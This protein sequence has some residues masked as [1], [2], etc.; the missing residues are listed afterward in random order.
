MNSL[1]EN[2]SMFQTYMNTFERSNYNSMQQAYLHPTY[3][4]GKALFNKN[5]KGAIINLNL[6]KLKETADYSTTPH[7]DPGKPISGLEAY[8]LYIKE[9]LPFLKASGGEI[10]FI[11]KGDSFLIGPADEHWDICMLVKQNSVQDF[12]S[13]EQ[14][15]EYMK[16]TG[17]RTAAIED[18][19]L[20]PLEEYILNNK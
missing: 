19:R 4:A 3:E 15:P 13:F 12:F 7:L 14:N 8:N 11:G 2:G 5:I 1:V 6:I 17:H 10:L 9:A 20:L 18:A 16:I